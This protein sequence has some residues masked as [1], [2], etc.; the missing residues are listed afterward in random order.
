MASFQSSIDHILTTF[1]QERA[2]V[3]W[4]SIW[5]I[6]EIH[7]SRSNLALIKG[8]F[9]Y[10]LPSGIIK[11]HG[12]RAWS[13]QAALNVPSLEGSSRFCVAAACAGCLWAAH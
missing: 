13:F 3:V 5:T 2:R 9:Q 10:H 4:R 11:T 7:F 1:N 6:F 8:Y 12:S